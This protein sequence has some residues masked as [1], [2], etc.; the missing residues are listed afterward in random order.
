MPDSWKPTH[1]YPHPTAPIYIGSYGDSIDLTAE[2]IREEIKDLETTAANLDRI[3]REWWEY[4]GSCS[5]WVNYFPNHRRYQP[6]RRTFRSLQE[7][8]DFNIAQ[9]VQNIDKQFKETL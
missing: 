1:Q 8:W 4:H 2:E 5:L 6:G 9:M 7:W 3:E